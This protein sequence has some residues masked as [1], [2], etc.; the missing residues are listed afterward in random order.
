MVAERALAVFK[1]STRRLADKCAEAKRVV[2]LAGMDECKAV[3]N[4]AVVEE[5]LKAVNVLLHRADGLTKDA[6]Q[7]NVA[8]AGQE[9][10]VA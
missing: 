5:D 10:A 3:I 1:N 8:N 9:S 7:T 2:Q 6:R 4:W